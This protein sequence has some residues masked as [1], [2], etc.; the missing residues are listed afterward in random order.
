MAHFD[1]S[2]FTEKLKNTWGHISF[3]QRL[4][5]GGLALLVI[6]SFF[7]LLYWVNSTDYKVLYTKLQP[8][9]AS[10]VVTLLESNKVSFKLQD[11]GTTILVPEDRVYDMRLKAAGSGTV[12]G[13]G[14][15]F[16]IFDNVQLGQTD[17]MQKIN[18]QRALQGELARTISDFPG[19]ERVRVHLALPQ[20][21][22]FV[23]E[24]KKPSA[25]VIIKMAGGSVL[26]QKDVEAIVNLV[27]M[28]VEGLQKSYIT[29]ADTSGKIL[30]SPEDE[31]SVQGLTSSQLEYKTAV[32]QNLERRIEEM[33]FPII[34]PGRVIAKVNADLDFDQRTTVREIFDPQSAVVRSEQRNE[35]SNRGQAN[36]EAGSADPNYRGDN[37]TGGLSQQQGTR[38][39]RTT[40]Y[41]INKE[42]HK[43]ISV[44][45]EIKRLSVA[46]I[47]DGSYQLNQE[48]GVYDYVPKTE[49]EMT[50]IRDLVTNAV[51]ISLE[52]GDGLEVSNIAFGG[53]EADLTPD[54]ASTIMDYSMRL[55]KPLLNA[56]LVF[57]F[58]FLVVRPVVMSLI[59]PKVEGEM[60]EGLEG[61]P[62]AED[63][64]ALLESAAADELGE[65]TKKI[66]DVKAHA[67]QL[68]EQN[69][70]QALNVL[71]TWM[72]DKEG[73]KVG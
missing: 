15:G 24:Q 72:K 10:R 16:E 4:L 26:N 42:E 14:V 25:S 48:T 12:T 2:A 27:S 51:G 71:R 35:E 32:Q 20:R 41:E 62:E 36:L 34:G 7:A 46:V 21:S 31:H 53:P 17:F 66:E 30:Y 70:A 49:E 59:R 22:L 43:I 50:R 8:E 57:L 1:F 19:V 11:D 44:P 54:L 47:V 64:L 52:R 38:E 68:S 29:I 6:G 63:R 39:S 9:D 65:P 3:S 28:S 13:Q 37:L 69:M 67:A 23:E 5:I 56:L 73:L 60:M 45:G 58:L 55:G 61:L 18:Y 40:N 33:L